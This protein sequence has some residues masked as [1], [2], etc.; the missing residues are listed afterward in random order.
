MRVKNP[1]K[2][3]MT[4]VPS[5]CKPKRPLICVTI[6]RIAEA[7]QKPEITG[8]EKNSIMNPIFKNLLENWTLS[9]L[10]RCY[11]QDSKGRP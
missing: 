11:Y 7:E 8:T 9:K 3:S 2:I 1:P 4:D 10:C 5:N 6:M